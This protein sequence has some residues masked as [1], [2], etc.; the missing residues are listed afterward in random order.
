MNKKYSYFARNR[1]LDAL[2]GTTALPLIMEESPVRIVH[3]DSI[4]GSTFDDKPKTM[5]LRVSRKMAPKL[6]AALTGL[7]T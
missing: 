5:D 1:F 2:F 6:F 3:T 7:R 4:V